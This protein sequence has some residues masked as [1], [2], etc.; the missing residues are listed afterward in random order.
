MALLIDM[1]I[2]LLLL[3]TLTYAFLVD[4]RVRTLMVALKALEPVVDQF[5][6]AVDRTEDSVKSLRAGGAV[7]SAAKRDDEPPLTRAGALGTGLPASA[8]A[9]SAAMPTGGTPEL[10]FRSVRRAGPAAVAQLPP[11]MARITGKADLVR[12]FFDTI[13]SREA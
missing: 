6:L 5:S 11:G 13:R 7:R 12:D 3:G 8:S 1:I 2:L 9:T 4:R 10:V